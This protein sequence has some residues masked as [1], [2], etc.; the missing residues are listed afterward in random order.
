MAGVWSQQDN[1]R[2]DGAHGLALHPQSIPLVR[3][4]DSCQNAFRCTQRRRS[5]LKDGFMNTRNSSTLKIG[6]IGYGYWGPNVVRYFYN[7]VNATVACGAD[8]SPKYLLRVH[9]TYLTMRV[10]TNLADVFTDSK[11]DPVSIVTP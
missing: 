7:A 4:E 3:S 8:I 2:R 6:V 10:S 9:Q 1:I 11:F 5:L